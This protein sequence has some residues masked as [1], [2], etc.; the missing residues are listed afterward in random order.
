[1]DKQIPLSQNKL[2]QHISMAALALLTL[3][4]AL[5]GGAYLGYSILFAPDKHTPALDVLT[6]Q[7]VAVG[8]AFLVG[9]GVLSFGIDRLRNPF[10]PHLARLAA[11]SAVAGMLVIYTKMIAKLLMEEYDLGKFIAHAILLTV[12]AFAV[13][14]LDQVHPVHIKSSYAFPLV[15][16]AVVHL[17]VIM[18]HY[19]FLPIKTPVSILEDVFVLGLIASIAL[20]FTGQARRIVNLLAYKLTKTIIDT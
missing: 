4:P 10:L 5:L 18:A 8:I 3:Y 6:A 19:I 9:I 17:N 14:I 1:M 11:V 12:C 16:L 13:L 15:L 7:L 2:A 20:L